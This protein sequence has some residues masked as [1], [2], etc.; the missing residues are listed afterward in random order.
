MKK[1]LLLSGT[2]F[3][4]LC[5][6]GQEFDQSKVD[7]KRYDKIVQRRV[8]SRFLFRK[9]SDYSYLYI[10]TLDLNIPP[11]SIARG[12]DSLYQALK[13]VDTS[14]KFLKLIKT[15]DY[16]SRLFWRNN[17][18]NILVYDS[19]YNI[20][21]VMVPPRR[22]IIDDI[23]HYNFMRIFP[24]V[25][26][27]RYGIMQAHSKYK[28]D[29]ITQIYNMCNNMLCLFGVKDNVVYVLDTYTVPASNNCSE[30]WEW[31]TYE[32]FLEKYGFDALW[33]YALSKVISP[34]E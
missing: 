28:W 32:E 13:T 16:N 21:A 29:Y 19:D 6:Y 8:N 34:L 14:E 33:K 27:D 25:L 17:I 2:L 23:D 22:E 5:S 12:N 18:W 24:A 10:Y 7:R 4:A 11:D 30:K 20:Q 26:L 15:P 3:F 1:L 31:P 9:H